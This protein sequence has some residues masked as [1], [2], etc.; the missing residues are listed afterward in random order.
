VVLAGTTVRVDRRRRRRGCGRL[1]LVEDRK[2]C[3]RRLQGGRPVRDGR[4]ARPAGTDF[5]WCG[6]AA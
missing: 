2:L 6:G 4:G 1:L 5:A 3:A